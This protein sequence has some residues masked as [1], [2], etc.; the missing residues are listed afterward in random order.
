MRAVNF[1]RHVPTGLSLNGPSL[2]ISNL[3]DVIVNSSGSASFTA[4]A[5]ATF[6]TQTPSNP[7]TVNGTISY[8]WYID[9]VGAISDGTYSG[10][11]FSGTTT[12][13]LSI[14]N[15]VNPTANGL[16]VFLRATFTPAGYT[17]DQDT[18]TP[19]ASNGPFV[20][21]N[22]ATITVRPFITI[23]TQPTSQTVSENREA[24]FTIAAS[25]S[26]STA[27]N[28]VYQWQLNG[29][30]LTNSS[31][32]F[33]ATSTSLRISLEAQS[34]NTIRCIVSHPSAGNS[35]VTS[36]EVTLSVIPPRSIVNYEIV[37]DTSAAD[38]LSITRD[39]NLLPTPEGSGP[40]EIGAYD[41]VFLHPSYM[42]YSPERDIKVKITLAGSRGGNARN[43]S[44]GTV[45]GSGGRGG[46]GGSSTFYFILKKQVEYT[47]KL[48]ITMNAGESIPRAEGPRGGK[49]GF[50]LTSY[51]DG[52]DGG[53]GTFFYERSRLVACV[54]GGGG[55]GRRGNGGDGG[56]VFQSGTPF[57]T[58]VSGTARGGDPINY[59]DG[60]P[61]TEGNDISDGGDTGVSAT[62]IA[63]RAYGGVPASGSDSFG[64]AGAC[65]K[66]NG[67]YPI[68]YQLCSDITG[69]RTTNTTFNNQ[70]IARNQP[71][72][73][74]QEALDRIQLGRDSRLR[75]KY[76]DPFLTENQN[77]TD[78]IV[79]GYKPGEGNRNNGGW[80]YARR[81]DNGQWQVSPNTGGGGSG[82]VG[83]RS[84][85]V[86]GSGAGGGGG[87][88]YL[89]PIVPRDAVVVNRIG[90]NASRL[91]YFRIESVTDEEWSQRF[92]TRTW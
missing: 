81:A 21:S 66:G 43:T 48:G 22:I 4:T 19:N 88:G 40:L 77:T 32:V 2:S 11:T 71:N 63:R 30:N 75:S 86:I 13:T 10:A 51:G 46:A 52:G 36:S 24:T 45:P 8:R 74:L 9:G 23:T 25:V 54:G 73:S 6:P 27:D 35:P 20:D 26:D 83:G 72:T 38:T 44:G 5:T 90:D 69:V 55:G 49:G 12:N 87:S 70:L 68:L 7:A 3:D 37:G 42:V 14:T 59:G 18:S 92:G 60:F 28:L 50:R 56:G 17:N 1:F 47:F 76:M 15:L 84:G 39:Y 57:G 41:G 53:G 78:L 67:Q 85:G 61:T 29:T 89:N 58:D 16:R 34:T 65:T 82:A 62:P 31:T 79:R 91:G 64:K 33:G 80:S